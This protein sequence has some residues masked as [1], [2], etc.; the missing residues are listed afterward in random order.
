MKN[1]LSYCYKLSI[2]VMDAEINSRPESN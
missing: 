1:T 2:T